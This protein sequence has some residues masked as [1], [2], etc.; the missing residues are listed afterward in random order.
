[1]IKYSPFLKLKLNEAKALEELP[2]HI[3]GQI[4]PLFDIPR[5][6]KIQSEAGIIKRIDMGL[7]CLK[8]LYEEKHAIEFYIDNHDIDDDVHLNG[9]HQYEYILSR[10]FNFNPIPVL[11]LDRNANHNTA[12]FSYLAKKGG[13]VAIRLQ[14]ED[15]E[16]YKLT[17]SDVVSLYGEIA[18]YNVTEVHLLLDLRVISDVNSDF[19]IVNSFLDGFTKD[20]SY[21]NLIVSGSIIPSN[22]AGLIGTSKQLHVH[23]NEKLLWN[24]VVSQFPVQFGDYGV[25]SPDY[26]DADLDPKLL[27]LVSTPK[28]FY[29]YA[30]SFFILRGSSL[31]TNPKGNNQFFD[32]ADMIVPEAF[33]RTMTYS[34]GDKYI[35]DRSY[36]SAKKPAKAG[37]QGSWIKGMLCAHITYIVNTI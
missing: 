24:R 37:S 1:M 25:V 10:F 4:R 7:K 17:K 18:K 13:K 21:G 15:I 32:I 33:Y 16:S 30:D 11:A 27:R 12:A 20:F 14:R 8:N 22:I 26:S 34:Y 3:A 35:H 29:P 36:L 19:A 31:H 9:M 2:S 23:R 28:V 5:T 6:T